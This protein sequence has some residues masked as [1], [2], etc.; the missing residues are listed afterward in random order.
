[1]ISGYSIVSMEDCLRGVRDADSCIAGCASMEP[2][3]FVTTE[4]GVGTPFSN[5][6]GYEPYVGQGVLNH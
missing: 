4:P 3:D 1:M 2:A 5:M 6:N